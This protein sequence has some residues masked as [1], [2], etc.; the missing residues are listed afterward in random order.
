MKKVKLFFIAL[1]LAVFMASCSSNHPEAVAVKFLE[2]GSQMDFEGAKKYCDESTGALLDM[3]AS[4][5]KMAPQDKKPEKVTFTVVSS[6]VKE[7]T[8]TVIYKTDKDETE[9]TI[10]LKKNRG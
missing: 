6:E 3:A 8:A 4:F 7:D 9:K 1:L 10:G 2:A 5:A